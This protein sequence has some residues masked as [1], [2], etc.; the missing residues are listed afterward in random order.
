MRKILLTT[1][2]L[3]AT[4]VATQVGA[5]GGFGVLGHKSSHKG[6]VNAIGVHINVDNKGQPDIK[7]VDEN[8]GKA[9][10]CQEGVVQDQNGFC[11]IC[12]NGNLY[13]SYR[14]DPC[15][16]ETKINKQTCSSPED[17]E[18]GCCSDNGYCSQRFYA[19][20]FSL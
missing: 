13:L 9:L 12:D 5:F 8:T 14:D 15:G 1:T 18:S 4:G 6:G 3:V 2:L 11:S 20:D 16:E 19:E 10:V 7:F 17:C